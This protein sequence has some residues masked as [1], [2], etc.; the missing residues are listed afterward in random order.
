MRW[1]LRSHASVM[2]CRH[3]SVMFRPWNWSWPDGR[4]S[5]PNIA[6]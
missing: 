3:A 2:R 4:K 1:V 5:V 6:S